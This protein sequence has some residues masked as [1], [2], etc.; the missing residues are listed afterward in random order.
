MKIGDKVRFLNEVGGGI[1]SGFQGRD[2]VLVEDEDGFD[3]PML[4]SECVVVATDNYNVAMTDEEIRKAKATEES[5]REDALDSPILETK[6]GDQLSVHLV[7][8]PQDIK[9]ISTTSFDAYLINDSNYF[10]Y[11]TY[12]NITSSGKLSARSHDL[13][14][15][16][17]KIYVETFT[18]AVLND[19]E[20]IRIQLIAFKHDRDYAPKAPIDVELKIDPVKF[21]KLHSFVDTPYFEEEVLLYDVVVKDNARKAVKVDANELKEALLSKP[22][23]KPNKSERLVKKVVKNAIVE[24]DLHIDELLDSTAGMDNK[25]MLECQL[26]EFRKVMDQ[27][28]SHKNQK[29]VFIHG[30]GDGV[31]RKAILEELKRSYSSC[32]YQ[33]ASFQEYGFGATMITIR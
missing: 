5:N 6:E 25:A 10:M 31:L 9:N 12:A 13:I 29:I 32:I 11:Y 19:L 16:N 30:K 14:A 4:R 33:D 2:I 23:F 3:I 7:F 26:H 24:I 21:Y 28:L 20:N 22:E 15:P 1:I 17:T 8:S 18:K 27:N